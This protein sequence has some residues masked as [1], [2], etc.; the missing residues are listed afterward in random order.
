MEGWFGKIDTFGIHFQPDGLGE[1]QSMWLSGFVTDMPS[2]H[3]ERIEEPLKVGDR[4]KG[5]EFGTALRGEIIAIHG[6]EAWVAW[7]ASAYTEAH[8][9][10][11]TL[12][13]LERVPS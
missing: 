3:I 13:E 5:R 9:K 4:V 8:M 12:S 1:S 10:S 6:C 2:F 11:W 7:A